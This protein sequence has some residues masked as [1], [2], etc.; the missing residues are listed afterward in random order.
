LFRATEGVVLYDKKTRETA[1]VAGANLILLWNEIP[2]WRNVQQENPLVVD[3]AVAF[4]IR[5]D[6]VVVILDNAI[7]HPN[8]S[9][10]KK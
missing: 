7:I 3:D 6:C 1:V 5:A 2:R 10:E 9:Q 8:L 4:A